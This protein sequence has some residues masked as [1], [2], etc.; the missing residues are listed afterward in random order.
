MSSSQVVL[1]DTK[2]LISAISYISRN[3][4]LP[5]HVFDAV[6][7]IYTNTVGSDDDV[8]FFFNCS[9]IHFR[10]S[11]LELFF[12]FMITEQPSTFNFK[13]RRR[14]RFIDRPSGFSPIR[15][16]NGFSNRTSNEKSDP[17]S[18]PDSLNSTSRLLR[19]IH[20]SY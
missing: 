10:V 12:F 15:S 11:I 18:H 8:S 20:F 1:D 3:L 19:R 13:W 6:S 7:S 16:L 4:P 9:F 5:P 14:R 2:T 17:Y